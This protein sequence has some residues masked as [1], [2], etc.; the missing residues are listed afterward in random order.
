MGS[1]FSSPTVS[2][3]FPFWDGDKTP[4]QL[5]FAPVLQP[6]LRIA[7]LFGTWMYCRSTGQIVG[8]AVL[9]LRG[10]AVLTL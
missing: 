4:S 2:L 8:I 5:A 7:V 3:F 10:M 9:S 1:M 6:P